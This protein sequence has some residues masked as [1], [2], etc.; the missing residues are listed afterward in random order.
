MIRAMTF[1]YEDREFG[2]PRVFE[3]MMMLLLVCRC[4]AVITSQVRPTRSVALPAR[5]V[6]LEIII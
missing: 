4:F 3:T 6:T 1:F 5:A 2:V